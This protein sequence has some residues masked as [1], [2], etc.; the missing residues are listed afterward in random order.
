MIW[1]E[2]ATFVELW[3]SHK[4]HIQKSRLYVISGIP[5]DLY[6][7]DQV[8]NWGILFED[9]DDYDQLIHIMLEPLEDID[10]D[11]FMTPATS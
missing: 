9:D 3:N 4:I 6:K 5:M 1:E 8:R 7:T 10:I 2:F 11:E